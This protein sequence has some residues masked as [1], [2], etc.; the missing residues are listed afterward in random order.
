MQDDAIECVNPTLGVSWSGQASGNHMRAAASMLLRG[1]PP[2]LRG[3]VKD[4]TSSRLPE[5]SSDGGCLDLDH[6]IG[7]KKTCDRKQRR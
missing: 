3:R 7:M 6:D 1:D 5:R 2:P 4:G